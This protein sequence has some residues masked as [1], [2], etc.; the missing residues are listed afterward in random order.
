MHCQKCGLSNDDTAEF[1]V[2]CGHK[3]PLMSRPG[4][5]EPRRERQI[6]TI[7]GVLYLLWVIAEVLIANY[8][9]FIIPNARGVWDLVMV[10]AFVPIGIALLRG[11]PKGHS[12]GV[13]FAII[14][15]VFLTILGS[16]VPYNL[17]F[18]PFPVVILMLLL[19]TKQTSETLKTLGMTK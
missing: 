3:L 13:W 12:W 10:I 9:L 17:V 5:A 11:S 6:Y 2:R 15:I 16:S 8:N 19:Q 4:T 14:N 18:L 1:C 7:A